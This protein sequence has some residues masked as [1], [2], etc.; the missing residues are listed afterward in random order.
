MHRQI[1]ENCI[2]KIYILVTRC[3]LL[4][5]VMTWMHILSLPFLRTHFLRISTGMVVGEVVMG[6]QLDELLV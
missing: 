4:M 2:S 6:R 1:I 3:F 5:N